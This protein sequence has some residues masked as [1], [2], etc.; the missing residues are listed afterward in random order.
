MQKQAKAT[1]RKEIGNFPKVEWRAMTRIG[2]S[3]AHFK[4]VMAKYNADGWF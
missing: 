1:I 4:K 2:R 3:Y